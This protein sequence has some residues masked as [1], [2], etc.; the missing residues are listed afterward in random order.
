MLETNNNDTVNFSGHT[1]GEETLGST[2]GHELH[3]LTLLITTRLRD[4]LSE[5]A[6]IERRICTL[7][8]DFSPM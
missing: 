8:G 2:V 7:V 3:G 5:I 6:M 1:I 4:N